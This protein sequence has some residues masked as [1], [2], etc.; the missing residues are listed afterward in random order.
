MKI[1]LLTD[2]LDR[3]GMETHVET[4]AMG[5]QRRG[6]DVCILSAGG[7]IAKK[8]EGHGIRHITIPPPSKKLLDFFKRRRILKKL[9]RKEKF[10]ILHAHTRLTALLLRMERT[11]VPRVVTVHARFSP[12]LLGRLLSYWGTHTVAVSRDLAEHTAR[13][14]GIPRD[15]IRII[16]NGI[17]L[18]RFSPPYKRKENESP[19]ILFASRLDADCAL[20]ARL[21]LSLCTRPELSRL[22]PLVTVAGGGGAYR[23]LKEEAAAVNRALGYE[24]VQLAGHVTDM[25]AL[26]AA[27]DIFV[28]V[29]RAAMEAAA[30]GCAVI[31]CGDEGYLGLLT[32]ETLSKARRTNLCCRGFSHPDEDMLLKSL[33]PLLEDRTKRKE[34]QHAAREIARAHFGEEQMQ[35]AHLA[36]YLGACEKPRFLCIGGYFGCGNLGDDLILEG[37]LSYMQK[38]HPSVRVTVFSDTSSPPPDVH[39]VRRRAP[40]SI[41]RAF[42]RSDAFLCGGGSLLQNKTGAPSLFYYLSLLRVAKLLGARPILYA[43]GIGPLIGGHAKRAVFHTL[44]KSPYISLRDPDSMQLLE[45]MGIARSRLHLGAD[46]ALLLPAPQKKNRAH[47]RYVCVIPR[48]DTLP[49]DLIACVRRLEKR[50]LF[51]VRVLLFDRVHDKKAALAAS[52]ALSCPIAM[53]KSYDGAARLLGGAA[54][55]LSGRLHG[56]VLSLLCGTPA[57]GLC[58]DPRDPKISSFAHLCEMPVFPFDATDGEMLFSAANALI[59]N[60]ENV[61]AFLNGQLDFLR[62]KGEKDLENLLE[63]LYNEGENK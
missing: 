13:A 44:M 48:G 5:L 62:K 41:L 38:K 50:Y 18:A 16:P 22:H 45:E 7:E 19:R 59:E 60:K 30:V 1:L 58:H 8:L 15:R 43:A 49:P 47:D 10:D 26:L 55:V 27:H 12:S 11:K 31:L 24:A 42:L 9:L 39:L 28:G 3:G 32:R 29:S 25:P 46:A 21:L 63:L 56:L 20:G 6:I 61:R 35:N 23:A 4:L 51:S 37:F 14:F 33:L 34:A 53:P 54:L 57:I 52:R 17:D 2:R 36:L 40:F